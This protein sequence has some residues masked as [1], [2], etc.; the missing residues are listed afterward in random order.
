M[1]RESLALPSEW[2]HADIGSPGLPGTDDYASDTGTFTLTG[3]GTGLTNR[4]QGN[5]GLY[6][7]DQFHFVYKQ[8]SGDFEI[9]ARATSLGGALSEIGITA[10]EDLSTS[11]RGAT[12]FYSPASTK[13]SPPADAIQ[14]VVRTVGG[15][16]PRLSLARIS[17]ERPNPAA[18]PVWFKIVR[19]AGDLG[20]YWSRD[21][22]VWIRISQFGGALVA[23]G[24]INVGMFVASNSQTSS[25]NV[26]FDNV[27]V[28]PPRLQWKTSWVGNSFSQATQGNLTGGFNDGYVTTNISS[29]WV[30]NDGSCWTN[31]VYDEAGQ[32]AKIY[33]D[34]GAGHGKVVKTLTDFTFFGNNSGA[35]GS[36]TGDGTYTYVYVKIGAT[37]FIRRADSTGKFDADMSFTSTIG[38]VAGLGASGSNHELYVSDVTNNKILVVDTTTKAELPGRSFTFS[39]GRPGPMAVDSRGNLW[40][41]QE[42]T[43]YPIFHK[44][45]PTYPTG[46]YCYTKDGVYTGSSITDVAFPTSVAIDPNQDRL[47]VTDNGPNQNVRIY[48]N[49]SNTA[50]TLASTFGIEN[51]VFSGAKPGVIDDPAS[52]GMA[53]FYS[54]TGVGVDGSGN[55]FVACDARGSDL[56]KF[57]ADGAFVWDLHGNGDTFGCGDFDPGSDGQDMFTTVLHYRLDYTQTSPGKEWSYQGYTVNPF[58]HPDDA[59]LT[60]TA[61]TYVRRAGP[62]NARLM[63]MS[64][65]GGVIDIYRFD[66][67]IAIVAGR[68][69]TIYNPAGVGTTKL[70]IDANGDGVDQAATEE[71][72][73]PSPNGFNGGQAG[74]WFDVDS[75]GDIWWLDG[76]ILHFTMQG[77][78]PAGVPLYS[79]T[80]SGY[81]ALPFPA[82]FAPLGGTPILVESLKYDRERDVMYLTGNTATLA[83]P[84]LGIGAVI[85]R[86]DNWSTTQNNATPRYQLVL[87]SASTASDFL[88]QGPPWAFGVEPFFKS[89]DVAGDYIFAWEE[90]GQIHVFDAALANPVINIG[91]GPEVDSVTAWTDPN[92]A[93][94][95]KR[96]TGEYELT[97][98]DS[99]WAAK[100]FLYRWTP[101]ADTALPAA[102]TGLTALAD[103][104][105]VHLTW[106]GPRGKLSKYRV[107]RSTSSGGE[108]L[109]ADDITSPNYTDTNVSSGTAYY[110]QVTALNDVGESPQSSEVSSLA[111]AASATFVKTDTT[112]RGNWKG[113]YG[114]IGDWVVGDANNFPANAPSSST[115]RL[116][117]FAPAD[118]D[119]RALQ[120]PGL[121]TGR[122]LSQWFK[123]APFPENN[124]AAPFDVDVNLTDGST[125]QIALY[126]VA[127]N[128]NNQSTESIQIL[129]ASSGAVLDTQNVSNFPDGKYLVWNVAGHVKIHVVPQGGGGSTLSG[130]FLDPAGRQVAYYPLSADGNYFNVN[131]MRR[132][133]SMTQPTASVVYGGAAAA[134]TPNPTLQ[135]PANVFDGTTGF[136]FCWWTP[137]GKTPDATATLTV[138]LRQVV[139]LGGIRQIYQTLPA[140]FSVRL[141]QTLGNWS[142]VVPDTLASAPDMTSS[143]PS[144]QARYIE[145]TMKG[146]IDNVIVGLNELVVFP[147]SATDPAP[148][149]ASHLDLAYLPGITLTPNANMVLQP[150]AFAH[151]SQLGWFGRTAAMG[152]TGDATIAVDLGQPYPISHINLDFVTTQNWSSGGMVEVNDGSGGWFTVFDSGRG[153]PVRS[154]PTGAVLINFSTRSVRQ[155]RLTDYIASTPGI[156]ENIEIF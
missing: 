34:D 138:D 154:S 55:I 67:E 22:A 24:P 133:E 139:S 50:P 84:A 39:Q 145:L 17:S 37:Q 65:V 75:A 57:T 78:N 36:I 135:N 11:P 92:R 41:I 25:T 23:T 96:S 82:P 118:T 108:T 29:L 121:A 155:I 117:R 131:L 13:D 127:W 149:S 32:A 76:A 8:V 31:S 90:F 64:A 86:Y 104:G 26:T 68:L 136:A 94:A 12:I 142:Q 66:G 19:V 48:T 9:V 18:L 4:Y 98:E 85:S 52:G 83:A 62:S 69:S 5:A 125:H 21:G 30:A 120:K 46:I 81:A 1:I 7:D 140:S 123:L 137:N 119:L 3:S 59:R 79:L 16:Q 70:W 63:F 151:I 112:T 35:E 111:L 87:P 100:N 134:F 61:V 89:F 43:D 107:Y 95:F 60:Q 40:I 47:L 122:E 148:S 124:T 102:P 115:G 56:R 144:I 28:G 42:A 74:T 71:T 156:M 73:I 15:V 146:T 106:Q 44:F 110:Y 116:Q 99:G 20:L 2:S 126:V 72:S 143:F 91:P 153:T 88:Q 130:I 147:G 132:P 51:G 150:R 128:N 129:D 141:A 80:G 27:Y 114:A 101:A 113:V 14:S 6:W 45:A 10:R 49:L 54:P 38:Q 109:Y 105:A 53:R 77:L 97:M 33:K 93:H 58:T 152:G 103:N